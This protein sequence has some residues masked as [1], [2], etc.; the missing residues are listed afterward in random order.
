M[1]S[2]YLHLQSTDRPLFALL[3]EFCLSEIIINKIE[4]DLKSLYLPPAT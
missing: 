2:R 1:Y 4:L 3:L